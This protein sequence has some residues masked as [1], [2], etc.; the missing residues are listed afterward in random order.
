MDSFIDYYQKNIYQG[1]GKNIID[2]I[3]IFIIGWYLTK[4]IIHFIVKMMKKSSIDPIVISFV[5]QL[6]M[7]H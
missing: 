6:L 4:I 1:L 7:L 2:A 3:L 5:N